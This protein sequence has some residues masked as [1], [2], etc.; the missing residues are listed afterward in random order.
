MVDSIGA[1]AGVQ[2]DDGSELR[3]NVVVV[4]ADPFVLQRLAGHALP[5]TFNDFIS[6]LKKDGTTM[7]V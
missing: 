5:Q 1:A 2:L 4:N 3:A 6:G 7:K